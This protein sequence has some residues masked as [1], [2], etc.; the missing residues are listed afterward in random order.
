MGTDKTTEE[1]KAQT[2]IGNQ[3]G[4][5]RAELENCE[6]IGDR[7]AENEEENEGI[8]TENGDENGDENDED[9]D[10]DDDDDGG[11]ITPGNI[12]KVKKE[13][14]LENVQQTTIDVK[15]AC[16]TT[17]FAMQVFILNKIFPSANA[18]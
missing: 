15:S 7:E 14:G 9:D 6:E 4:N 8:D 12:S 3:Y 18:C 13:M 11:W 16:L 17:D 5:G 2:N 10:D 1:C